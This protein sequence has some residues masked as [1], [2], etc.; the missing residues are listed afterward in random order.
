MTLDQ[1]AEQISSTKSTISRMEHGKTISR[2]AVIRALF[3]SYGVTGEELDALTNLAKKAN[4]PGWWRSYTDVLPTPHVDNIALEAEA[5]DICIFEPSSVP[6]LLQT[7]DYARK[8]MR[9]GVNVLEDAEIERRVEARLERQQRLTSD[10]PP[11]LCAILDEAVL[12]HPVG[13]RSVMRDQ[14]QHL[15]KVADMTNVTLQMV[16]YGEMAHPGLQGSVAILEFSDAEAP[17]IA[18]LETVAG[19]MI[20]DK[21]NEV[22]HC[23]RVFCRL[24]SVALDPKTSR[25][26]IGAILEAEYQ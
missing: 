10:Q 5:T 16:P 21:P 25:A 11:T 18:V 3:M 8:I 13:G 6:G 20:L 17:H 14:L 9:D 22:R 1:A 26:R 7:P 24:R 15:L 12:R 4:E 23:S 19:D 2:P